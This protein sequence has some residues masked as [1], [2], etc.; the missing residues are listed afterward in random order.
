[1]YRRV[2]VTGFALV[3]LVGCPL[4]SV[5]ST[6]ETSGSGG[7]SAGDGDGDLP[8]RGCPPNPDHTCGALG[9][10]PAD[11][12]CGPIQRFDEAGCLRPTCATDADCAAD[13]ICFA[14][15]E[16]GLCAEWIESCQP[17][18]DGCVCSTGANQ[19]GRY[20]IAAADAPSEL[21]SQT[22]EGGETGVGSGG[23]SGTGGDGDGDGDGSTACG[24]PGSN[25]EIMGDD[26]VCV[27]GFDWCDLEDL[28]NFSCCETEDICPGN[29][30][31]YDE[32]LGQCFCNP[33]F[34]WCVPDD[35]ND[36]SCCPASRI[37]PSRR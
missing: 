11:G 19:S 16:N 10:D 37:T 31:Y 17:R 1:M 24:G 12:D 13:E 4:S 27:P 28:T 5:E 33:G 22:C 14:P 2:W 21:G 34:D 30:N 3:G 32:M 9:C 36:Y 18:G 7:G 6:R 23:E 26:C 35:P 25:S 15:F 20:C 8:P 29:D